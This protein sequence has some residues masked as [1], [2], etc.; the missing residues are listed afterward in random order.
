MRWQKG[1]VSHV[2]L[3]GQYRIHSSFSDS[4]VYLLATITSGTTARTF[5]PR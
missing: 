4:L 3:P 2:A 5:I 1:V